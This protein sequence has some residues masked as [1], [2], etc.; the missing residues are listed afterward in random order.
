MMQRTSTPCPDCDGE[1][2]YPIDDE[3]PIRTRYD[4]NHGE[5][6]HNNWVTCETCGGDGEIEPSD[7]QDI[8]PD[9]PNYNPKAS[10][11]VKP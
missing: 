1:G 11:K 4:W 6:Y 10:Y 8:D 5:A 7:E 3:Q 2:G 9:A